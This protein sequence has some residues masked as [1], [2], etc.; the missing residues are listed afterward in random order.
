MSDELKS[1]GLSSRA[2]NC[3]LAADITTIEELKS[4]SDCE[5]LRLQG[6]GQNT[7]FEIQNSL[8][9]QRFRSIVDWMEIFQEEDPDN[10]ADKE[11]YARCI[12][13]KLLGYAVCRSIK[14]TDVK[15]LVSAMDAYT[16]IM[17]CRAIAKRECPPLQRNK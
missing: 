11:V 4:L 2:L 10:A 3:L 7:L 5:L 12:L 13:D 17:M 8:N 15:N 6:L 1:L 9:T 14:N 16:G